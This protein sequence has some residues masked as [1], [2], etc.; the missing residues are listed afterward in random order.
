[1]KNER[2]SNKLRKNK[3]ICKSFQPKRHPEHLCH[4]P[5]SP[6]LIINIISIQ[7]IVA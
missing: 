6:K 1:M 7:Y 4:D 5:L 2:K 3:A